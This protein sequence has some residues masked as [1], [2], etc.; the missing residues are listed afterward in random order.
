MRSIRVWL[1]AAALVGCVSSVHALDTDGAEA[2][3][4]QPAVSFLNAADGL[5]SE[6]VEA[7]VQDRY[8]YLWIGTR[9]GLVRHEGQ[10][11]RV[12]RHDPEQP[13]SLP[14]NNIMSLLAADDGSLWAGISDQGLVRIDDLE[15]T[16]HWAT[17]AA[18][19]PLEGRYI[20]SIAQGCDGAIWLAFARGGVAR[21]DPGSGAVESFPA[22]RAGI[23]DD[24]F[25]L[26]IRVG[27]GCGLWLLTVGS[28]YRAEPDSAMRFEPVTAADGSPVPPRPALAFDWLGDSGLVTAGIHGVHRFERGPQGWMPT[29]WAETRKTVTA[30]AVAEDG[31]QWLAEADRISRWAPDA[32]A[33]DVVLHARSE[34]VRG[35]FIR[36]LMVPALRVDSEGGVWIGTNGRGIARLSPG[37]RGFRN[38]P[39]GT[40]E[41]RLLHL[42]AIEP[43]GAGGLW[44]LDPKRGL[45]RLAEDGSLGQL[46]AR[47]DLTDEGD[48]RD[49]VVGPDGLRVLTDYELLRYEPDLGRVE[50]QQ[51]VPPPQRSAMFRFI[52]PA[53]EGQY[54]LGTQ[55]E[56]LRIDADGR[57]RQRWAV[58]SG[59]RS[60]GIDGIVEA[61][62]LESRLLDVQRGPDGRWWW[63]GTR[64]IARLAASGDFEFI[65]VRDR[66]SNHS[67]L[68]HAGE[69]WLASDSEL[70]RFVLRGEAPEVGQRFVAGNGLPP[71]RIQRLLPGD[72]SI[73]L[74]ITT[75]LARLDPHAG[76]FR[77]FSERE[78]LPAMRFV[79]DAAAPLAGGRFAA[80]SQDGVLIVDPSRIDRA[81]RPPPV[82]LTTV[83]A[84]DRRWQ[85]RPEQPHR[86]ELD[87][88]ETSIEFGFATLSFLN[89]ARNRVRMRL[90][91]W[92][93]EWSEVE[94]TDRRYYGNLAP[95]RYR[96]EIQ[97]ANAA[98][99]WNGTGDAVDVV[100]A[101]PP[102]R[103]RMAW[104]GYAVAALGLFAIGLAGVRRRRERLQ[105]RER[106]R[107]QRELVDAQRRA[108]GRLTRSLEPRALGEAVV[109][110]VAQLTRARWV[111]LRFRHPT[112]AGLPPVVHGMPDAGPARVALLC[113]DAG[114]LAELRLVEPD[115]PM[116]PNVRA[117]LGL[118]RATAGQLLEHSMLLVQGRQLAEEA[119]DAS[120]AKSEFIATV[121]H[122][123]RTPLHALGGMLSLLRETDLAPEQAEIVQTLT[124]STDQLRQLL[125]DSLDLSRIEAGA[126]SPEQVP[127]E[128][129][130]MLE[131]VVDLHAP[132][133]H[134][135]GVALR[136]RLHPELPAAGV[137]DEGRMAQV[138]GN[139]LSNAI[140]FTDSGGIDLEARRGRDGW[141]VCSVSDTGPGI[142]LEERDRLFRPFEQLESALTRRVG[143]AGLGLAICRR[144]VAVTGG[145]LRVE[146]RRFGG[147]RFIVEWP[148]L[149]PR[150]EPRTG[151]AALAGLR[152]AAD[153]PAPELRV[154]GWLAR[155][156]GFC[157]VDLPD[158]PPD[159]RCIDVLI[160]GPAGVADP[161]PIAAA[162][163][164]GCARLC[165]SAEPEAEEAWLRAPLNESR[166]IGALLALRFR[167]SGVRLP[168]APCRPAPAHAPDRRP[169]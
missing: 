68:F 85:L 28:L 67:W 140:K 31:S 141:L 133:A 91:G 90:H 153:L 154:L 102:W 12:F 11:L 88:T 33:P 109:D 10:R 1:V 159:W 121:S 169:A 142:P 53:G 73:W 165:L 30:L 168:D 167:R 148:V 116:P 14:G 52:R 123:I 56:L 105:L 45:R 37:W 144:L 39:L 60:D 48:L 158:S 72:E 143:G 95:G 58:G 63:L 145:E 55:D 110:L 106:S 40:G 112:L 36:G 41:D 134:S 82:H 117:R 16:R 49:V 99:L 108:L 3:V 135:K 50:R 96:F 78:G 152:V 26:E 146:T 74:L 15:V 62:A 127:F 98:G 93:P 101:P 6:S 70:Q 128:L 24:E 75:G 119:A 104:L 83:R 132:N 103:S 97:A 162:R 51:I 42:S 46:H 66:A 2:V 125:D 71:G 54:W 38:L 64:T 80:A 22:G 87:W 59:R 115:P 118:L 18:G 77:V 94:A 20:W 69:L 57:V 166:L 155:C 89:P 32:P 129:V 27:P 136:L 122:E 86:I 44:L 163:R 19:G 25:N 150:A 43:D 138:L 149:P 164:A 120:A 124:R 21:V 151:I 139:L 35:D 100:I 157:L 131:R 47:N 81:L 29:A 107:N 8:G 7:I 113:G 92:D 4:A 23:P 111:E 126:L 147:T 114:E 9:G 160:H 34:S 5:P 156:W 13:D 65:Q 84:G 76:A 137:G 17:S 130:P 161:A 61:R 79:S